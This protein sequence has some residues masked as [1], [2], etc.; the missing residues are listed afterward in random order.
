MYTDDDDG[1]IRINFS[2]LNEPPPRPKDSN[3]PLRRVA[4]GGYSVRIVG[5][6]LGE[7]SRKGTPYLAVVYRFLDAGVYQGF[8]FVD[9]F[10]LV[11]AAMWRLRQL[12]DATGIPR[13]EGDFDPT[14]LPLLGKVVEIEIADDEWTDS[15]GRSHTSS[16]V[17]HI[18]ALESGRSS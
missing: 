13:P 9:R 12:L 3:R 15:D 14:T 2:A 1:V 18:A 11:P 6:D 5:L 4:D 16:K 8:R 17:Q 7:S 10:Y